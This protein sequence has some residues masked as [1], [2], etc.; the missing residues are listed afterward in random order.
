M[1]FEY[2]E[3]LGKAKELFELTGQ[4][5]VQTI[6]KDFAELQIGLAKQ[7][8]INGNPPHNATGAL[9]QSIGFTVNFGQEVSIDFLMNDYWDFIN[10]GVNGVQNN[11]GSP[12]SF[13]SLNPSPDM[14]DAIVGTGGLDGWIRAKG[15]RELIYIDKDGDLIIKDLVTDEDFRAAAFVFAKGIKRN[16][17]E[18]NNF[19]NDVFNEKAIQR[20]EE[21]IFKAL[22]K[23]L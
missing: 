8:L 16:G 14:V 17:I 22:N 10:E 7:A 5:P 21:E 13:R 15:I 3:N 12:Y 23:R 1:A 6:M 9:A 19:I 11:F 2:L 18:G 20:F 4:S